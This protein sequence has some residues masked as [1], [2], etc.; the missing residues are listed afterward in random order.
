M[1]GSFEGSLV[2][3]HPRIGLREPALL[4]ALGLKPI[5]RSLRTARLELYGRRSR[6][7]RGIRAGSNEKV[8][9]LMQKGFARSVSYLKPMESQ[10]FVGI[11]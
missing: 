9:A 6:T 8:P 5:F 10:V 2:D 3:R 7:R 1:S 4:L 11:I